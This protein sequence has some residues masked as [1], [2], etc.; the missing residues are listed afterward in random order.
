MN[1]ENIKENDAKVKKFLDRCIFL[2]FSRH[3]ARMVSKK[4][5]NSPIEEPALIQKMF[6][7]I[8]P[9]Y[10]L[11]NHLLSFGFDNKWRRKAI[12]LLEEKKGGVFLDI[13][14]GSGDLSI[15]ALKLSPTRIVATDFAETMLEVFK[16]KLDMRKT[17]PP[18][19]LV[20][21]DALSLPFPDG[22][23]DATM[24]AFGIRNFADRLQSL[25]EM[26]RV[27][28]PG[29]ISLILELS[30]P[31]NA[32]VCLFYS[33]Y[34]NFILP[35]L[36]RVISRHNSAYRYLPDS[37]SQF[38]DVHDFI[39]LMREAGFDDVRVYSL[40]FGSATIYT[41]RKPTQLIT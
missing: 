1:F 30:L 18:I 13:A 22:D 23:F 39:P 4:S 33:F 20:E 2:Q 41:G 29:G 37:I 25:K 38:P 31:R 17:Y 3:C 12:H 8:A 7:A 35:L 26:R 34:A 19:E 16:R 9:T 24:V 5:I 6:N 21:C 11:L 40:T 10:D 15:E 14:C 28:K 32:L 27:L 36:G